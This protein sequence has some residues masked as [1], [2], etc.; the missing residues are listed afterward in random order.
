MTKK[1]ITK[2]QDLLAALV[3]VECNHALTQAA[4]VCFDAGNYSN[5]QNV[6]VAMFQAAANI[7]LIHERQMLLRGWSKNG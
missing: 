1:E 3:N 6:K 7:Q 2:T 4:R 5:D